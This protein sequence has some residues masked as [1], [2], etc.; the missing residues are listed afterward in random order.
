MKAQLFWGAGPS[1][2]CRAMPNPSVS[3]AVS[4]SRVAPCD[5]GLCF[6][7]PL[8]GAVTPLQSQDS[9]GHI[10]G[11]RQNGWYWGQ[12]M[13]STGLQQCCCALLQ[14]LCLRS[15]GIPQE[16]C[17][18]LGACRLCPSWTLWWHCKKKQCGSY[19]KS[20]WKRLHIY[21]LLLNITLPGPWHIPSFPAHIPLPCR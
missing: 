8:A 7:A 15:P 6:E 14:P 9:Q 11:S 21:N 3:D 13:G 12:Q 17:V 18:S 1:T 5:R 2:H 10:F 20:K 16:H 4:A 19:S